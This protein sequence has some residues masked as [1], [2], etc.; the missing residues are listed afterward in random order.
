MFGPGA[1]STC[2]PAA[3]STSSALPTSLNF[4][5]PELRTGES[6]PV[7]WALTDET[8]AFSHVSVESLPAHAVAVDAGR[9]GSAARHVDDVHDGVVLERRCR[10]DRGGAADRRR[11]AWRIAPEAGLV[12]SADIDVPPGNEPE[13]AS[14][15]RRHQK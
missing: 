9:V 4:T 15:R 3:G 13:S 1:V 6:A 2:V 11:P 5:T 8:A 10:A 12:I 7:A 14:G